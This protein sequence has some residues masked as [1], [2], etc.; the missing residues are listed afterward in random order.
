[1]SRRTKPNNYYYQRKQHGDNW[2]VKPKDEPSRNASS[3]SATS[4]TDPSVSAEVLSKD[5]SL[6]KNPRNPRWMS[7]NR[8]RQ[9]AK[10]RF[11]QK[12][13][14]IGLPKCENQ[15]GSISE[16]GGGTEPDDP[17]A[18]EDSERV[19][20]ENYGEIRVGIEEIKDGSRSECGGGTEP[21]DPS[22]EEDSE[23]VLKE[24]YGEIRVGTEEIKDGSDLRRRLEE[25]RLGVEE[26]ELS[27]ELLKI[28][29]Q[30]QED[31][32]LALDSIYGDNIFHL[33][34]QNGLRCVQIHIHIDVPKE[35][36]VSVNLKASTIST[37]S[38][39]SVPDFRYSFRVEHLPPITLSCLLP[40]SYPSHLPPHFTMS[41]QWLKSSKISQ[42]CHF[43]D[44]IWKEQPGQEVIYQW[45]E[46]LQSSSLSYLQFD[47]ELQL[48]LYDVGVME[49][50]RAISGSS[51]P[52]I[53]IPLLRSYDKEHR[54]EF[55]IKNIQECC[56]CIG[57]YPGSE[58]VRLPCQHFFCCKCIKTFSK[59]HVKEGTLSKLLC[60]SAKCGG[61]DTPR[62]AETVT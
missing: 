62:F 42:L 24:N 15:D 55:F 28:N 20:K 61:R 4:E 21:D 13:Q 12:T 27:E 40:E 41:V 52:D 14:Q 7:R 3:S 43:L 38:G 59:M 31:E 1:M 18:E 33:D 6:E 22:A 9:A 32:L 48:S 8:Y 10:H 35:L 53:D 56:I 57:E 11:L 16:C 45:V 54:Y 51:S 29:G 19:L 36:T 47:Q 25:L 58:F 23:G 17:S 37:Q 60:P 49:D 5:K 50:R 2:I 39:D 26:P 34:R 44:S 46:W 30:A